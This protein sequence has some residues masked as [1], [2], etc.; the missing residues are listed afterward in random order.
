MRARN[1]LVGRLFPPYENWCRITV[2]TEPEVA[3][4]LEALRAVTRS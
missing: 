3:A 2:G 4:F 1:I